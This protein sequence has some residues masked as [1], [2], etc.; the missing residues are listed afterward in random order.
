MTVAELIGLLRT[1]P[2]EVPVEIGVSD[3]P[4]GAWNTSIEK[5]EFCLQHRLVF[6]ND[7]GAVLIFTS[8]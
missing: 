3:Q 7:E 2:Q 8:D 5:V 1:M 4:S 6:E